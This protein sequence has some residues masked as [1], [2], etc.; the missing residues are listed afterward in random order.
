[1]RVFLALD[2]DPKMRGTIERLQ[3]RL[4]PSLGPGRLI[5]PDK[6]HVT[7]LFFSHMGE[8]D[9]NRVADVAH[10]VAQKST[11]FSSKISGLGVFRQRGQV[12]TLWAGGDNPPE[13]PLADLHHQILEH[14]RPMGL[15]LEER[16]FHPHLTL[17]RFSSPEATHYLEDLVFKHRQEEVGTFRVG[18]LS[19]YRSTLMPNGP[20]YQSLARWRFERNY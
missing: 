15:E 7:L 14:I 9:R 6:M 3:S 20:V 5:P 8:P 16:S 17:A 10:K 4:K 13:G 1:M 19:F 11:P 2:L 18:H 12:K